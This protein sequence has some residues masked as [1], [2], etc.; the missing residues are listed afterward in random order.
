MKTYKI[1]CAALAALLASGVARAANP[2]IT[3]GNNILL[4]NRAGQTVQLFVTG[5]QQVPGLD[6]FA[7]V[8]GGGTANGGTAGPVISNVNL[9]SGTIFAGHNGGQVNISAL[10]TQAYSGYVTT[11]SGTV[12]ASG[13]LA[14][15]TIDTTGFNGGAIYPLRLNTSGPAGTTYTDFGA[16]SQFNPIPATLTNGNLIVLYPGDAD[17]NGTVDLG[18]YTTVVRNYGTGTTWTQ[19]HFDTSSPNVNLTDYTSVVR[20]FGQSVNINPAAPAFASAVSAAAA[21]AVPEPATGGALML[22]AIAIAFRRT[23]DAR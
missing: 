2:A 16:D 3:V 11:D 4:P 9:T 18:D 14:T 6:L 13:L 22:C 12:A 20:N 10:P 21:A 8:A 23:R 5:G 15:L 7:W 1:A 17:K 19:G